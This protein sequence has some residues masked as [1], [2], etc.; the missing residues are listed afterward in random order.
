MA[1][2]GLINLGNTCYINSVLQILHNIYELNDYIDT[3]TNYNR[4]NYDYVMTTEWKELKNLMNKCVNIS[5]NRFIH[6]NNQLFKRKNKLEFLSNQPGDVGEYF[7]FIM[8]CI[9]NSFNLLDA[10]ITDSSKTDSSIITNLFVSLCETKFLNDAHN[11]VS[12]IHDT[13]WNIDLCIPEKDNITLYDCLDHSFKDEYLSGEDAWFDES[14]SKK[15]N[16]HKKTKIIHHP[17]ILVFVF[18]RW[19]SHNKRNCKTIHFDKIIDLS[20]YSYEQCT[21]ELFGII[22]HEGGIHNGHYVSFLKKNDKWVL[23]NDD[24]IRVVP[25]EMLIGPSNYCLFYRKIK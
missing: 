19:I 9:H 3:F 6:I 22:N 10:S 17:T 24:V 4:E 25:D 1:C 20:P 11:I 18:K 5:P 21:Y 2:S 7:L 8:E 23:F 12:T 14:I 13:R 16:V 15:I